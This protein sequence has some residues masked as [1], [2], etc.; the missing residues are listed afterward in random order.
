MSE[1]TNTHLCSSCIHRE[2]CKLKDTY[3]NAQKAVNDARFFDVDS[4]EGVREIFVASLKDW[5]TIPQLGCKHY[6]EEGTIR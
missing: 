6:Q 3:L 1:S 2:I 5:L 4:S